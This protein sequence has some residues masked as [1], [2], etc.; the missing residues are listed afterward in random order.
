M[1]RFFLDLGAE[2]CVFTMGADGAYYH[3]R[4]GTTFV[5]PAFQIDVKCTCGCGDAF[6]AGFAAGLVRGMSPEDTVRFAQ[7]CS[8]LNATGLGS[9]AGVEDFAQVQRFIQTTSV[10]TPE[11]EPAAS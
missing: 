7:A 9:Q 5:V 11:L 6:N 1:A 8:A 2:C 3:H 10:R 4:N